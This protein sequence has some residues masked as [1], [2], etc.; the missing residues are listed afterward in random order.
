MVNH[1]H[2]PYLVTHSWPV[3]D[4]HDLEAC[5]RLS[6]QLQETPGILNYAIDVAHG[7]IRV[8]YDL[9]QVTADQ[10]EAILLASNLILAGGFVASFARGWIHYTEKNERDGLTYVPRSFTSVPYR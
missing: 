4:L 1:T 3:R 7:K 8:T 9:W 2:V 6:F 5:A 10:V